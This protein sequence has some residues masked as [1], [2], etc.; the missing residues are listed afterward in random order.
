MSALCDNVLQKTDFSCGEKRWRDL[1]SG[2]LTF[3]NAKN[4][5]FTF[6]SLFGNSSPT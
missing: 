3:I 2:Y 6:L 4:D 5:T 1:I